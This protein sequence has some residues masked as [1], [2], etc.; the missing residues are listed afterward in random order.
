MVRTTLNNLIRESRKC[1]YFPGRNDEFEV[2][3]GKCKFVVNLGEKN[4]SCK[5]W[6]KSG[7]P[8]KHAI[9]CIGYKR[10]NV[11]DFCHDY[12]TVQKYLACYE[13]SLHS[14]P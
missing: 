5:W 3:E 12:F 6:D 1:K 2:I 4:C 7:L 9:C 14:F 10:A 13:P 8:C 11:E